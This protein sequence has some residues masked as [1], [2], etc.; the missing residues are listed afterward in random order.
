MT[1]TKEKLLASA[2]KMFAE[3][4][5][6]GVS[7][8]DLVTISMVNLCSINYYFGSKQKLYDAVIDNIIYNV[9]ENLI[10]KIDKYKTQNTSAMNKIT[11]II[12]EFFDY[13]FSNKISNS[14]VMILFR[15]LLN[16][17][18]GGDRIYSEIMEPLKKRFV[19]L[20]IDATGT[21]NQTAYIKAQCLFSNPIFFRLLQNKE[22]YSQN[23]L[24]KTKQQLVENCKILLKTTK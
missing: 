5:F 15:E 19:N 8:R 21:D 14:M 4:G 13:L 12:S 10:S 7:T 3:H 1:Q 16:T 9:K 11:F 24:K 18:A 2:T 20:I 22:N 23:F 17:S 6:N